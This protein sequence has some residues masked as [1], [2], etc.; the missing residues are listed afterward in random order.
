MF[1]KDET[2][3]QRFLSLYKHDGT[4][5]VKFYVISGL[6]VCDKSIAPVG[7]LSAALQ[8]LNPVF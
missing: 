2:E 1:L 6:F 8:I 5:S 3:Y 7:P 4:I